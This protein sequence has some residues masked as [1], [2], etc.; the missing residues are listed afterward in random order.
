MPV[1]TLARFI[2]ETSLMEYDTVTLRDSKLAAASLY[3]A[4]KMKNVSG[5]T[6][7][8]EFYTGRS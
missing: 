2:L 5:W 3:L 8:L 6:N 1:L 4:L 7:T